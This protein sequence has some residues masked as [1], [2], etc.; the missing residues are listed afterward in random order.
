MRIIETDADIAEG[1][2]H[3]CAAEPRFGAARAAAGPI[4]LRRRPGGY[5]G[6]LRIIVDQQVSVAAGQAIWSKVEAGGATT[7]EEVLSRDEE[8]LRGLGLSRPKIRAARAVAEAACDGRLCFKRQSASP[9]ADAYDELIA[10]KG[11]GPWTAEIYHMF[12]EGRADVFA[13]GDL[14]LQE[15]A[16]GLFDLA[17]R[18]SAKALAERSEAWS[19]WRAVAARLLWAY[20]RVLKS[21]EGVS[22]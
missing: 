9:Y 5:A 8:A 22:A 4:P 11:V 6:L 7:P 12:C 13:P 2:D 10:L 19:P 16:R 17:E 1:L 14:A 15:A 3:L 21:R 18:P 20:Y